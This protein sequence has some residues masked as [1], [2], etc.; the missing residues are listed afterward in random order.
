MTLT[1][2]NIKWMKTAYELSEKGLIEESTDFIFDKIDGM[3]HL[4]KFTEIDTFLRSV[5]IAKLDTNIIVSILAITNSAINELK[6]YRNFIDK[7]ESYF[8]AV[9]M[10]ENRINRI[11]LG[12]R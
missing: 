6:E 5:D 12:L 2:S 11:M 1:H 4:G 9:G 10:D 3:L 8:R 7:A